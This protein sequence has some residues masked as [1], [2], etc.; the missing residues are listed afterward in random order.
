MD[1]ME[2]SEIYALAAGGILV[3]L[4]V[5]RFISFL[6]HQR[7]NGVVSL[8]FKHVLYPYVCRRFRYFGPISRMQLII[9]TVYWSGTLL[10]NVVKVKGLSE[11]G[12]RAGTLSVINLMPLLLAN[13]LG[14]AADLLGLSL[15]HFLRLHG[16]IALMT[17]LQGAFHLSAILI[18]KRFSIN[19]PIQFPGLLVRPANVLIFGL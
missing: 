5:Y 18:R 16:T 11:A 4:L 10:C 6:F 9:Q 14:F 19:D 12:L 2:A 1:H 7:Y 3:I 17:F 13:P 8:F 15:R